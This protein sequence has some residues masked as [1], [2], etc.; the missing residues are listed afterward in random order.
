MIE[1]KFKSILNLVVIKK[2]SEKKR[3]KKIKIERQSGENK[4]NEFH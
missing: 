3:D 1:I 2:L 4:T